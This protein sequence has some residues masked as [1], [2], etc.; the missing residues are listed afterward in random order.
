MGALSKMKFLEREEAI[1]AKI[2]AQNIGQDIRI[3][4]W[5]GY[6]WNGEKHEHFSLGTLAGIIG[7]G[8]ALKRHREALQISANL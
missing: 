5:R 1:I 6:Y 7:V 8:P 3:N 4:G 2:L